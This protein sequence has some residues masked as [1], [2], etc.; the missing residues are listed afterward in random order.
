MG[1]GLWEARLEPGG[2]GSDGDKAAKPIKP[3]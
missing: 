1:A 2:Q 3:A